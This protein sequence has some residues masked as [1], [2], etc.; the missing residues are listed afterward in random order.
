MR[1]VVIVRH[2]Q[3]YQTKGTELFLKVLRASVADLAAMGAVIGRPVV[4]P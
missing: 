2:L 4:T 3:R 1:E